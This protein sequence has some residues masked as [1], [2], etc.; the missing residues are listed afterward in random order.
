MKVV[1]KIKGL[2]NIDKRKQLVF[3][4]DEN[5][6]DNTFEEELKAIEGAG[7][8]VVSADDNYF[9]LKYKLEME[10]RGE[11]VFI[12]HPFKRPSNE[13]LKGYP[14]LDLLIANRELKLDDVSEF[15]TRYNLSQD[16]SEIVRRYIKQLRLPTNQ[17]K[18]SRI[19]EK[20]Q[21]DEYS[22][23]RGL[24]SINLGFSSVMSKNICMAKCF[25][26]A[27]DKVE[28]EKSIE[29]LKN[30]ELEEKLLLWFN[31][32]Y[33]TNFTDLTH[34]HIMEWASKLKYNLIV[35]PKST[36]A[37]DDSYGRLKMERTIDIT[38]LQNF[39]EDWRDHKTLKSKIEPV[40]EVLGAEIRTE[41]I[42]KWYK[43]DSKFGYYTPLMLSSIINGLYKDA[44]NNIYDAKQQSASWRSD[45]ALTDVQQLEVLFVYHATSALMILNGYSSFIF[46]TPEDFIKEYT[47]NLYKVDTNF[48]KAIIAYE[49]ARSILYH[50]DDDAVALYEELNKRYDSFLTNF[51]VEW[52]KMLKDIQFDFHKIKVDKQFDFYKKHLQ[53]FEYKMVVIVSD[54]FRYELGQEL[55]NDL[56]EEGKMNV[57]VIPSL[58]SVPSYTNLGMS[59]LLPNDGMTVEATDFGLSFRIDGKT[60]ASTN[61][62]AILQSVDPA[63]ATIGFVEAMSFDLKRGRE[64]FRDNRIVYIYHDWIDAIGDKRGTQHETLDATRRAMQD[65]KALLGKLASWNVRHAR[66]TSDHGFLYNHNE[67]KTHNRERLPSTKGFSREHVRFVVA[68]EF[69]GAVDGYQMD[70]R[71]TTNLDTDLKVLVPRATN[72]YHIQGNIGLQFVHGGASMQELLTPVLVVHRVEKDENET[73][74]F[75]VI[76]KTDRIVSNFMKIKLLQDQPVSNELKNNELVFAIYSETGELLSDEVEVNLNS[77]S[78]NPR[79][80]VFDIVLFLNSKGS[81]SSLGRVK[82]FKKSNTMRINTDGLNEIVT[83]SSLIEK[84]DF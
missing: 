58:A 81:S 54:A 65:I 12:Y 4:F 53:G 13:E 27:L 82:A 23:K 43:E 73:V 36:I 49:E 15:L 77:T 24:I 69:E 32:L 71:N 22:L 67:I 8:K 84:D 55:C 28:F 63:S 75:K 40:F 11:P 59:N 48:R 41:N 3:Y 39:Y 79:E 19:L 47:T 18:L 25:E 72:R 9:E 68:E 10:W 61:R 37:K 7:I 21:F 51:N 33:D 76:E 6:G 31:T 45:D 60:T 29:K 34:S 42:L 20:G 66:V 57:E 30:L 70:L 56:L 35:A 74:S 50:L 16:K 83:I 62:A 1:E 2:L 26:L 17:K 52:Q 78:S 5:A 80:R 38:R 46:N 44:L 64:F 14:L